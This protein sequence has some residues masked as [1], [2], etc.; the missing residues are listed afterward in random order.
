MSSFCYSLRISTEVIINDYCHSG[1]NLGIFRASNRIVI[2]SCAA[3]EGDRFHIGPIG[4]TFFGLD[5]L[6]NLDSTRC[7]ETAFSMTHPL[8]QAPQMDDQV[9]G[10]FYL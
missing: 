6:G 5:Y 9:S 2:S 4:E 7:I 1:A 3:T 10:D 8:G